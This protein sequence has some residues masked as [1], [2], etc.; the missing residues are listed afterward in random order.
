MEVSH[1]RI[2]APLEVG[3]IAYYEKNV[4]YWSN[5]KKTI[6]AGMKPL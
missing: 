3:T 1:Q 5:L 2:N 6:V 4:E